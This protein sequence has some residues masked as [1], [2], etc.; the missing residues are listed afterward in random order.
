M[1]YT[2]A[3][4]DRLQYAY[5]N[6]YHNLIKD[7]NQGPF[8]KK[9]LNGKTYDELYRFVMKFDDKDKKS[10]MNPVNWKVGQQIP[11]EVTSTTKVN[12]W[13][14][15]QQGLGS[16]YRYTC[17]LIFKNTKGYEINYQDKNF[18]EFNRYGSKPAYPLNFKQQAEVLI[19]GLFEVE[20]IE[21]DEK[22]KTIITLVP[23][24]QS[25]EQF[26]KILQGAREA[27]K[28]NKQRNGHYG[29][30]WS[31]GYKEYKDVL[32]DI[33]RKVFDLD[34]I[35]EKDIKFIKSL[36]DLKGCQVSNLLDFG[37][38]TGYTPDHITAQDFENHL[39]NQFYT[40]VKMNDDIKFDDNYGSVDY[41]CIDIDYYDKLDTYYP[42]LSDNRKDEPKE[43]TRGHTY[44]IRLIILYNTLMKVKK[45]LQDK[46][47]NPLD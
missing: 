32:D 23:I 15:V 11:F 18:R 31:G 35:S 1:R 12:D 37:I 3:R 21:K 9:I 46:I 13:K 33:N 40:N 47:D 2:E 29:Y 10:P 4:F 19:A 6:G 30:D 39:W 26:M 45:E 38:I 7:Y 17:R 28:T 14:M 20:S 22:K 5:V 16:G 44:L 8:L 36:P 24:D 42:E 41:D 43:L 27:R 25:K 34:N